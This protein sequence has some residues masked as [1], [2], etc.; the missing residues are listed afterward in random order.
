MVDAHPEGK[1]MRPSLTEEE[2]ERGLQALADLDRFR[3]R[4]LAERGGV[5]L[6]NVWEE[7]PDFYGQNIDDDIATE[8]ESERGV[9]GGRQMAG[10]TTRQDAVRTEMTPEELQK[11]GELLDVL[12]K[13][14]G[15]ILKSND[16]KLFPESWTMW[17][18]EDIER[19]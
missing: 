5:P 2:R 10:P 12:T 1:I 15:E 19:L 11:L 9:G 16:G 18:P 8:C 6:P 4:L 13:R 14:R 3:A 17:P 7:F